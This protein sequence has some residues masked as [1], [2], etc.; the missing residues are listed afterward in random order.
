MYC[1]SGVLAPREY[2][3]GMLCVVVLEIQKE[4]LI[5]VVCG[6]D[7]VIFF[8]TVLVMTVYKFFFLIIINRFIF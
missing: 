2:G 7:I 4:V 1:W 3:P 6:C 5:V 8:I